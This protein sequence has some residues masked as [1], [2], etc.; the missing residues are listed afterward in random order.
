MCIVIM[1]INKYNVWNIISFMSI[2][3]GRQEIWLKS[4]FS[5]KFCSK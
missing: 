2:N 5:F 3:S 1:S 4:L